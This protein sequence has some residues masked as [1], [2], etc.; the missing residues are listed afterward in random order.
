MAPAPSSLVWRLRSHLSPEWRTRIRRG[1]D[2]VLGPCGSVQGIIRVGSRLAFTVDDGP[3]PRWT[4]PLLELLA[5]H[6]VHATFFLLA[7]RT[8]RYPTIV[9]DIV[10]AGHEVALHG[11]DHTRLTTLPVREVRRRTREAR[12]VVEDAAQHRVR[13]FRP[14]FGAQS[15]AIFGAVRSLGLDVAVWGPTA[16][17]WVDGAPAD[18]ANRALRAVGGGD[19]LLMHDGL[20]VPAGEV[21]PTFDRTEVFSIVLDGLRERQLAPASLSELAAAGK[22]RRTA[23]FRP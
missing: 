22:L 20:E 16:E 4:P 8:R 12:R 2:A 19:V 23:W 5:E 13:W 6:D 18:V 9:R 17:D 21:M 15:V 3:D 10:A 11:L 14:P 1:A 7:D